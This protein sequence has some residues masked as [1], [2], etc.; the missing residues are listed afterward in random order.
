MFKDVIGQE[1]VKQRLLDMVA[2][3]RLSHALL[4]SGKEGVGALPLA[5]AFSQYV[6]CEK[7]NR[8]LAAPG[9]SLFGDEEKT[10]P[11]ADACGECNAC[12]K[13]THLVHPDIHF[14]YPVIPK[15]TGDKP[16]ST[17]YI[18]EWREFLSQHPYGNV[19]DWLQF[20]GAENKQGNITANEC[21]DIIHKLS[22]KSFE[23]EYKILVLWM[24]E[25]LGN[26]GNKLLKLIEEPPPNT[27]FILVTENENLV[28]PTILSRT[29]AV[30]LPPLSVSDIERQ[31]ALSGGTP[32]AQ[33]RQI[34]SVSGGNYREAAQMLQHAGEDWL[35]LT[36]EWLNAIM[37]SGP[38]AQVKWIEEIS[39]L[40]REKQKQF[41]RYFNHLMGE[42]IKMQVMGGNQLAMPENER[43]FAV[44]INRLAG[45]EQLQAI[46]EECDK[47]S[48]Y[49]ERNAHAKML[50]HALTIRLY[51]II[52]DKSLILTF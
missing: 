44:R 32:A 34:A 24:P 38:L 37:K 8:S 52:A 4:F 51:H 46:V 40:G 14:S 19:Y 7:V 26:E 15:K 28:L 45:I 17:D 9:P 30:R 13:S 36:R 22:L 39:K 2:A 16:V 35:S 1:G 18:N 12:K 43:D 29:Q 5:I 48:Y 25:Y 3:N 42:A 49:I 41:L 6:V 23:S 47:A 50:F 27:L 20:I 33:A 10:A 11:P 31:L 21:N